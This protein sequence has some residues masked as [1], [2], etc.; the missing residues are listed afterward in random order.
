MKKQPTDIERDIEKS[1]G[2]VIEPVR[3]HLPDER[4]SII[5]KFTI[6]H[7]RK[8]IP[9]GED[10][11]PDVEV[12]VT[13]GKY[14]EGTAGEVFINIGKAGD[15][16][17]GYHMTMIAMSLGLQYGVPLEKYVEKFIGQQYLPAGIVHR[18]DGRTVQAKS[19][20]D[21]IVKWLGEKF[22]GKEI[23]SGI[24]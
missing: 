4:E 12:Y 24:G 19:I 20:I 18:E 11:P 5:H 14:K 1:L 13:A 22:L 8:L 3:R 10:P 7:D 2:V 16:L 21:Y 15:E 17:H 6:E 9:F 23:E